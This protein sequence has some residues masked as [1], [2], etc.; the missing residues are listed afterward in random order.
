MKIC[1][2]GC[3]GFIGYHTALKLKEKYNYDVYGFDNINDYY[4]QNLKRARTQILKRKNVKFNII[5]L[6]SKNRLINYFKNH[7]F[8]LVVHLGAYAGVRH[9]MVEPEKYITNNIIGTHNLIEACKQSNTKRVVYA[10][11]SCVMAGNPL[12]WKEDEKLGYQLNPYGYSKATNESQFMASQLSCAIGLRFF[13]VYGPWGRPDMALFDFTKN[14]IAG[15]PIKLFN[16]GEMIRDFTYIDDI[17]QGI[18][19]VVGRALYNNGIKDVYNIGYGQQV[20]LMDFVKHIE[21][22]LGRKAITEMAPKHPADTKETWSD[23][24]KLQALGYKPTTPIEVGVRNFVEWYKNY[25]GVN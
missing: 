23:T 12:P 19:L 21:N 22:N 7:N 6:K 20:H 25:Y 16:N 14:I 24:T 1:I 13:T 10:S 5:D 15:N 9:S 18:C 3:A 2:T 11:T 17:V 8:D 4:D